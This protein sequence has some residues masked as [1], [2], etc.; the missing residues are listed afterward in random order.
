[1]T[2]GD[3]HNRAPLS[4]ICYWAFFPS[5]QF[6]T[7]HSHFADHTHCFILLCLFFSAVF[8]VCTTS[9][10]LPGGILPSA[11]SSFIV[12]AFAPKRVSFLRGGGVHNTAVLFP[13]QLGI[14]RR[15]A[16][17]A[18]N[19]ASLLNGNGMRPEMPKCKYV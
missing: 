19:Q 10:W 3:G 8:Y 7:A 15:K 9:L 5:T 17:A 11:L 6:D 16:N 2:S 13:K 18:A 14:C 4:F 12:T 1:M